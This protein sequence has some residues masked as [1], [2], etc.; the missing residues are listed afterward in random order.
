MIVNADHRGQTESGRYT[1]R[2]FLQPEPD[3]FPP[4]SLYW[5]M[6]FK[7]AREEIADMIGE[8]CMSLFDQIWPQNTIEEYSW[9]ELAKQ[10]GGA[11][12]AYKLG[13]RNLSKICVA[14][15]DALVAKDAVK[16]A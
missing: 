11:I 8:D 16:Y 7:Q 9:K 12:N 3:D 2:P 15:W 14:A 1:Y 6:A 5:Q 4:D 10:L 13:E